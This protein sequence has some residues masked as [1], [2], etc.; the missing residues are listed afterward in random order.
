MTKNKDFFKMNGYHQ[1]DEIE[2]FSTCFTAAEVI[3]FKFGEGIKN[4]FI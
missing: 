3:N 1:E 2:W 4:E